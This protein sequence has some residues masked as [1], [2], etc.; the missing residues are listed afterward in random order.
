[1][2]VLMSFL[3]LMTFPTDLRAQDSQEYRVLKYMKKG[4]AH[5]Y[6]MV[7]EEHHRLGQ[8]FQVELRVSCTGA[9]SNPLLLDIHDSL[10]VCDLDPNSSK[11]NRT[12]TALAIK[13][14]MADLE[15]YNDQ[16]ASGQIHPHLS[17]LIDTEIKKFS[18][19]GLCQDQ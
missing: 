3:L 11:I 7:R 15:A 8:P 17:C 6:L 13:T 4:S 2:K 16:I 5:I 9:V 14:K 12:E 1:M 18:L 10:S 19:N